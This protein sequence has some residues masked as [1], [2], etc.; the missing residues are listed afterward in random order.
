MAPFTSS[1]IAPMYKPTETKIS[2]MTQWVLC[3]QSYNPNVPRHCSCSKRMRKPDRRSSIA[4][5]FWKT[6]RI[7]EK[8]LTLQWRVIRFKDRVIRV[9]QKSPPAKAHRKVDIYCVSLGQKRASFLDAFFFLP[10]FLL[11]ILVLVLQSLS[12]AVIQYCTFSRV[13]RAIPTVS[14]I[15]PMPGHK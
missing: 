9:V 14:F 1:A 11:F 8:F 4:S 7:P 10:L 2:N 3:R 15:L 5:I 13:R 12:K 6:C